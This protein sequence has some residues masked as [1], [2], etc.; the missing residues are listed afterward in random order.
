MNKN[1]YIIRLETTADYRTVENINRYHESSVI[2]SLNDEEN[3]NS[4][5]QS[6][7]L[8]SKHGSQVRKNF[9]Y[10]LTQFSKITNKVKPTVFAV[11]F[12]I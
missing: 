10:T 1:D 12:L 8:K 2:E 3:L 7:R 5:T 6:F 4:L 9:S 11:G